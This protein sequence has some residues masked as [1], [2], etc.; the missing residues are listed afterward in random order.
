MSTIGEG[1]PRRRKLFTGGVAGLGV[2][3]VLI[4]LSLHVALAHADG[5][6]ASVAIINDTNATVPT[7]QATEYTINFECSAV[8]LNSCGSNLVLTV[9][10]A[11]TSTNTSGTADPSN[12]TFT[13]A[14]TAGS[15]DF[16]PLVTGQT[17]STAVTVSYNAGV[18][19]IPLN[20]TSI[21]PGQSLTVQLFV[22]QPDDTTPNNTTWTVDSSF[23]NGLSTVT[24][25]TPAT[26]SASADPDLEVSKKTSNGASVYV[27]GSQVTYTITANCADNGHDGNLY[28]NDGSLVD[29]LP[30]GLTYVSSNPTATS[31]SGQ[32]IAWNYASATDVP[33]GCSAGGIGK[34]TYS[35]TVATPAGSASNFTNSVTLSGDAIDGSAETTTANTQI[36]TIVSSPAP[37][38]IPNFISK[39]AVA[40]LNIGGGGGNVGTYPGRWMDSANPTPQYSAGYAEASYKVA[41]SYQSAGAFKTDVNDPVPCLDTSIISDG[42]TT[43]AS[44]APGTLCQNPAFNPTVIEVTAGSLGQAANSASN[45]VPTITLENGTVVNLAAESSVSAGASSAYYEIPSGDVGD[46]A[47]VNLP[48]DQALSDPSMNLFLWGYT[49]ASP[50]LHATNVVQNVASATA[51]QL[52]PPSGQPTPLTATH[53]ASAN[54]DIEALQPQLG[55]SK[56]FGGYT[57]PSGGGP[58]GTAPVHISGSVAL[59]A[60]LTGTQN[61]ALTDLLPQNLHW[62]NPT[63]SASFNV[64]E[65]G[66]G[67]TSVTGTII[68]TPNYNGTGQELVQITLPQ[69]PFTSGGYYQIS[70]ADSNLLTLSV[71]T[72]LN[73]Y[74]NNA[75]EFVTTVADNVLPNC[76]NGT[77]VESSDTDDLDGDGQVNED[78][79]QAT[80]SLEVPGVSGPALNLDKQVQGANDASFLEPS[81]PSLVGTNGVGS[82]TPGGSGTFKLTWQ[83]FGSTNLTNPVIYDILPYVGDTG[84]GEG[85]AGTPRGS[86]FA[87]AFAGGVN[88]TTAALSGSSVPSNSQIEVLYS[89]STNPCRPE[90]YANADN[91]SCT[92]DWTTTPP[93]DL[94]TVKALEFV[95][96]TGSDSWVPGDSITVSYNVTV[97]TADVN[98]IAWNSA[99]TTAE[100]SNGTDLLPAE[101]P[102]VGIEA[103]QTV[104]PTMST[105]ISDTAVTPGTSFS[106]TININGAANASGSDA[107]RLVGP[108]APVDGSCASL[109]WSGAATAA[110]GT[111]TVNADGTYNTPTASPTAP[112]CYSYVD[113]LTGSSWNQ[114]NIAP[115]TTA[116]TVLVAV[117]S[118]STSISTA[119]TTAGDSVKDTIT[120]TGTD[121]HTGE[122]DWQLLGPVAPGS[123]GTC[124]TADW[125]GA[126]T[127]DSGTVVVFDDGAYT[128]TPTQLTKFGC[129]GYAATLSGPEFGG[130]STSPVGSADEVVN[131]ANQSLTTQISSGSIQTNGSVS[132]AVTVAGTGGRSGEVDWQLLGPVSAG[133]DGTCATADWSSAPITDSGKIAISADGTYT[134]PSTQ[135]TGPGCYGY[136]ET[137]TGSGYATGVVSSLGSSGEVVK[138]TDPVTPPPTTTTPPTTTAPPTTTTPPAKK[139]PTKASNTSKPSKPTKAKA[140]KLTITKSVNAA[141]V[142]AG[143]SLT[144][145]I[146]VKNTGAGAA[147]D[148]K[149]SDTPQTKMSF[150]SAKPSQGTCRKGFPLTCSVDSLAA[151]GT[152]TIT[153]V[154]TPQQAGAVANDATVT[155]KNAGGAGKTAAA[156]ATSK[157]TVPLTLAQSTNVHTVHAGSKVRFGI[158]VANPT[159]VAA[160]A[161]VICEQLPRG[162]AFVSS[163]QKHSLRNGSIC[164]TVKSIPAHSHVVIEVEARALSGVSGK[165]VGRATLNGTAIPTQ[166]AAANVVVAP[167]PPKASAVTG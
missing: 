97:P 69:A 142:T 31:V 32:T 134:T 139:T 15:P 51:T 95:D 131:V 77:P 49:A 118:L 149:V 104:T 123:D 143:H 82:T 108:V 18:V 157:V 4:A 48:A 117:P 28:L 53:T 113:I 127:A 91:P 16:A 155:A 141:S 6:S 138:V 13:A 22:T 106:D 37:G 75:Q 68:D 78:Y 60:A 30:A 10:I 89:Q 94:S 59:P 151:G 116:E 92:S 50:S 107:W 162:L 58:T 65:D 159:G 122:I 24:A 96:T 85:Q 166:V 160:P 102:E 74:V 150:V 124:A 119:S 167:A 125:S 64:S 129:Y 153:V 2:L 154:A 111:I 81:S 87:A 137:L 62:S 103:P 90:V 109:D 110:S 72:G 158:K 36:S 114:V 67:S 26:G 165:L 45:W 3:V 163:S 11:L 83:N 56:S 21:T 29:T 47:Q 63:T 55:V 46:V 120:V 140:P 161:S 17:G 12:W 148:V 23:S 41:I 43:F 61:V 40:P 8:L 136:T 9:P 100:A 101:P 86:Q 133:S 79:C 164:W 7:G 14:G 130:T 76:Q 44:N 34:N 152:M 145:T 38:S 80:A 126:K 84:V 20:S 112:G 1:R 132:D 156:H 70:P 71:P 146:T 135:L 19:T 52:I 73:A 39:G 147:H 93:S 99:A 57:A 27:A 105:A 115:G 25:P 33:T 121:G 54:I 88:I 35:L 5:S 144:F 128:T 42:V 98:E 66:G